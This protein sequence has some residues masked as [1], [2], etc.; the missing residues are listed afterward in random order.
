MATP[1]SNASRESVMGREKCLAEKVNAIMRHLVL[2]NQ[3]KNLKDHTFKKVT[4]DDP[5]R[6]KGA[7]GLS[8]WGSNIN[9]VY[10]V[11]FLKD[12]TRYEQFQLAG[13]NLDTHFVP[14]PV[15][16]LNVL[17]TDPDGKN[18]R[19]AKA[20][21]S[22]ITLSDLLADAAPLAGAACGEGVEITLGPSDPE[23][24][25]KPLMYK[26]VVTFVE[27]EDLTNDDERVEM[28]NSVRSYNSGSGAQNVAVLM[29]GFGTNL[30]VL[31]G[32]QPGV[33]G[34]QTTVRPSLD[35]DGGRYEFNL[36]I[37]PMVN[38]SG[39][40]VKIKDS[41]QEDMASAKRAAEKGLSVEVPVGPAGG[42][43]IT[44]TIM[45]IVPIK[46]MPPPPPEVLKGTLYSVV[47]PLNLERV[48]FWKRT[49]GYGVHAPTSTVLVQSASAVRLQPYQWQVHRILNYTPGKA[50]VMPNVHPLVSIDPVNEQRIFTQL[51][52]DNSYR[53]FFPTADELATLTFT[54]AG[55]PHYR[56]I[57]GYTPAM[58]SLQ[59]LRD[60][61]EWCPNPSRGGRCRGGD[62]E[63]PCFRSAS[64][65]LGEAP[66]V[67]RSSG[68]GPPPA[69]A[70]DDSSDGDDDMP[71]ADP[72]AAAPA[73]EV[74]VEGPADTSSE[75]ALAEASSDEAPPLVGDKRAL[76]SARDEPVTN[77]SL[78]RQSRA[79]K[80]AGRAPKIHANVERSMEGA[81]V[82]T[83][84]IP[85][86][87]KKGTLPTEA[88]ILALEA[89]VG[90]RIEAAKKAGGVSEMKKLSGAYAE[91]MG[92]ASNTPLSVQAT[93]D[94]E[95]TKQA[96]VNGAIAV[97]VPAGMEGLF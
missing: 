60:H 17:L 61:P 64:S 31:E 34:S 83:E 90:E 84:T 51:W 55:A 48:Y 42:K 54:T 59:Q 50:I 5:S 81:I 87:I 89:L 8:C 28:A 82:V 1:N 46:K 12:G 14:L 72:T 4:W 45:A 53:R 33:Y 49:D 79:P 9:D 47:D 73:V 63:S 95:A 18:P 16:K 57:P 67:Y 92:A 27:F 65:A 30:K 70:E 56:S 6:F 93:C 85:V 88:D 32:D 20:D 91:L 7:N 71:D 66:P 21:G 40:A 38:A 11:Q 76:P 80:S 78:T 3:I 37:A 77:M 41:G 19:V 58:P 10:A 29:G 86:A 23:W 26:V 13:P 52:T 36:A 43:K 22:K 44:S 25:S 35:V 68:A 94:I 15:D 75:A 69:E 62:V 24:R 39:K 96:A 2:Q 97:G 74:A